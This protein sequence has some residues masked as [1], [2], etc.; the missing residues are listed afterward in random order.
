MTSSLYKQLCSR[1]EHNIHTVFF[2]VASKINARDNQIKIFITGDDG[3]RN[4]TLILLDL[5]I[6]RF[7]GFIRCPSHRK[8]LLP[9]YLLYILKETH[10][11]MIYCMRYIK[12]YI[13]QYYIIIVIII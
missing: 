10:I 13:K 11:E 8:I 2:S 9:Q 5:Y 4:N 1:K 12:L 3:A 7:S 6:S